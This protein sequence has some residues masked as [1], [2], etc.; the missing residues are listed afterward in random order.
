[1][2]N[3][4]STRCR[5]FRQVISRDIFRGYARISLGQ[6]LPSETSTQPAQ[7]CSI[8]MDHVEL[9][10]II[11]DHCSLESIEIPSQ[12]HRIRNSLQ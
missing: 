7:C 12:P 10:G 8:G 5:T 4:T 3:F 1:M 2:M 6:T 9:S 11:I